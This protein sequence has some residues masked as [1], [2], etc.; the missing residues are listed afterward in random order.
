M[1]T[2]YS[3]FSLIYRASR[4]GFNSADFHSKCDNTMNVIVIIENNY[5]YVF[6]GFTSVGW[7]SSFTGFIKDESAYLYSLRRNGQQSNRKLPIKLESSY[8][9]IYTD[10]TYGPV[11]GGGNDIHI[12]NRSDI[13]SGSHSNLGKTYNFDEYETIISR[14]YLSGSFSGWLTANIEVFKINF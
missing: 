6:G 11:F 12:R 10:S 5:N 8:L 2:G 9:A 7:K 1:L 3:N 13:F 4:D 14:S